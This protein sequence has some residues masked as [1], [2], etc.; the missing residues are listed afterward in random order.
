MRAVLPEVANL[1]W[2]KISH[3]R[4]GGVTTLVALFGFF[5]LNEWTLDDKVG[6]EIGHILEYGLRRLELKTFLDRHYTVRDGL[7]RKDLLLPVVYAPTG[8]P[9]AM[10]AGGWV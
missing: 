3:Q 4:V 1:T 7:R 10:A 8:A 6:R 5:R 9:P 2:R